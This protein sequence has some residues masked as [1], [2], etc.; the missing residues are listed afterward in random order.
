MISFSVGRSALV[1]TSD[2]NP[3]SEAAPPSGLET[4][5]TQKAMSGVGVSGPE[6]SLCQRWRL[7]M[8]ISRIQTLNHN[9][10]RGRVKGF[11]DAVTLKERNNASEASIRPLLQLF[12]L[13]QVQTTLDRRTVSSL[14]FLRIEQGRSAL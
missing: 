13:P 3:A 10:T 8:G 11:G 7:W 1:E 12:K 9:L 5:T 6:T 4:S 2:V 14:H